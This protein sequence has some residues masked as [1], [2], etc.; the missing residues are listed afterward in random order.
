[1]GSS[2]SVRLLLL[3]AAVGCADWIAPVELGGGPCEDSTDCESGVR[4]HAGTCLSQ[5]RFCNGDG[6]IQKGEDCDDGN[7]DDR[8]GCTNDC[9][10]PRCGDGIVR[11]DR[12]PG[13]DGFESCDPAA[14][15]GTAFCRA[16]CRL[17]PWPATV[18]TGRR[19]TALIQGEEIWVLGYENLRT[20]LARLRP[21]LPVLDI[22]PGKAR[23]LI[24]AADRHDFYSIDLGLTS[25]EPREEPEPF[26]VV[27][28]QDLGLPWGS[29][30]VHQLKSGFN[31]RTRIRQCFLD[32][33]GRAHCLGHN[34]CGQATGEPSE[35]A[36]ELQEVVPGQAFRALA[37]NWWASCGLTIHNEVLCWGDL[38]GSGPL[39]EDLGDPCLVTGFHGV[40]TTRPIKAI[41][42]GGTS[43]IAL[44]ETGKVLQWGRWVDGSSTP[45]ELEGDAEVQPVTLAGAATQIVSGEDTHCALLEDGKV[46]CW[47]RYNGDPEETTPTVFTDL[48][49][50]RE[51]GRG[52]Y[53]SRHFCAR[54]AERSLYCW[55][56]GAHGMLGD[57]GDEDQELPVYVTV[58]P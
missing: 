23:S 38:L 48:P 46:S 53:R 15:N 8:D 10:L 7:D 33:E 14:D 3:L 43:F 57:G 44:T 17:M 32:E 2:T 13:E 51:L 54:E 1:M 24:F 9:F 56:E 21:P 42:A 29:M 18:V 55:G 30:Q 41:S 4:C 16:D 37:V 25:S 11:R 6:Q 50:I 5:P 35:D 58:L 28:T 49:R 47:G 40:P 26:S 52:V 31:G 34:A 36:A 39:V 20:G 45:V 22:I 12:A 27:P 19:F